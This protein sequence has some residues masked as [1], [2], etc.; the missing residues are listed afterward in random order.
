[1]TSHDSKLFR[2]LLPGLTALDA[3]GNVVYVANVQ[4]SGGLS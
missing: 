3:R 4:G 2:L 1:M